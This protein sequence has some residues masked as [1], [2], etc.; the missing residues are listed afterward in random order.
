MRTGV[1]S[2]QGRLTRKGS[3]GD[4]HLSASLAVEALWEGAARL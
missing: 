2:L 3:S 4:G 1:Q